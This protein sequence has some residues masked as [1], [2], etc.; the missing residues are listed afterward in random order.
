M[1]VCI[2]VYTI[3]ESN[4]KFP[5]FDRGLPRIYQFSL[6]YLVSLIAS[7]NIPYFCWLYISNRCSGIYQMTHGVLHNILRSIIWAM[8]WKI[9]DHGLHKINK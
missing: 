5:S 8:V 1:T 7:M 2:M 9:F 4:I 6:D 3:N